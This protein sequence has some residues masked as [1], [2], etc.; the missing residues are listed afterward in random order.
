VFT[1]TDENVHVAHAYNENRV[2]EDYYS[3][4]MLLPEVEMLKLLRL[5]KKE[6]TATA[7]MS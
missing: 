2:T 4:V 7:I 6:Y 3:V 5:R 1:E